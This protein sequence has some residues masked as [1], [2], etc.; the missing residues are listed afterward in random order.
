MWRMQVPNGFGCGLGTMQLILYAFY[1]K[2]KGPTDKPMA[3]DEPS[4]LEMGLPNRN[5]NVN[6]DGNGKPLQDK[7]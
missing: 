7:A 6:G 4:S 3:D 2:N 1:R 5:G